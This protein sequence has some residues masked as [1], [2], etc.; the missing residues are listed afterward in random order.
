MLVF[1]VM[2]LELASSLSMD[3]FLPPKLSDDNERGKRDKN[4][5][6]DDD[7]GLD[8]GVVEFNN[9][10]DVIGLKCNKDGS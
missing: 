3:F 8:V 10:V 7:C 2:R 9:V 6:V 5:G 1:G 4:A